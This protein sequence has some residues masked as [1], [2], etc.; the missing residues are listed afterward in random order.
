[1]SSVAIAFGRLNPP[2]RGHEA[3]ILGLLST[4]RK[5]SGDAALFL[6]NTQDTKKNPLSFKEKAELVKTA[7]PSLT[8]GPESAKSPIDALNWAQALGY[9]KIQ[10]LVGPDR[11]DKFEGL[12]KSWKRLADPANHLT[13]SVSSISDSSAPRDSVSATAARYLAQ[14]GQFDKFKRILIS[15]LS[16]TQAKATMTKIQQRLGTLKEGAVMDQF[17]EDTDDWFDFEI[18]EE[19]DGSFEISL[20]EWGFGNF[21]KKKEE[22]PTAPAPVPPKKPKKR[23]EPDNIYANDGPVDSDIEGNDSKLVVNPPE[24]LIYNISN[25]L[26]S[27]NEKTTKD[28]K[29]AK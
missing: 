27:Q 13:L 3:L 24:R 7:F 8:I 6:S 4:A 26:A 14:T 29:S 15:R 1:M 22:P 23:Q 17:I 12:I 9:S 11:K 10:L 18:L 28:S 20:H 5:L 19:D 25:K 2:T 16:D 21:N